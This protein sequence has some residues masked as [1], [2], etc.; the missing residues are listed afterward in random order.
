[1]FR[2][3]IAQYLNDYSDRDMEEAARYNL[4]FIGIPRTSAAAGTRHGQCNLSRRSHEIP[5]NSAGGSFFV[6]YNTEIF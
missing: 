2:S 5:P 1:M 4:I 3:A 6:N